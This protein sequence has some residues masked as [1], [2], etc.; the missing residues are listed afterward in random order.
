[1]P[2]FITFNPITKECILAPTKK[3]KIGKFMIEVDVYDSMNYFNTYNFRISVV[4]NTF[5]NK[6]YN[7]IN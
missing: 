3:T 6:E 4:E 2:S 7:K 5:L 1:M